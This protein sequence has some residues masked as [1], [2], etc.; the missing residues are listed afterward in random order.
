MIRPIRQGIRWSPED[1]ALLRELA[2]A[3]KSL[4]NIARQMNRSLKSI[5]TRAEKLN[6]ALRRRAR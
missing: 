3:R 2:R 5:R 6:I 1:D 4:T